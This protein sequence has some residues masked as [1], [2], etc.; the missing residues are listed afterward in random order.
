MLQ[1]LGFNIKPI[2]DNGPAFSKTLKLLSLGKKT[3][4]KTMHKYLFRCYCYYSISEVAGS[5][6][7][8]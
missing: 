7:V 4:R 2:F 1:G 6:D 3:K 5:A 8:Y